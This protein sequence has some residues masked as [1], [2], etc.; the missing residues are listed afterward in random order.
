MPVK[1]KETRGRRFALTESATTLGDSDRCGQAFEWR[2]TRFDFNHLRGFFWHWT[3][4]QAGMNR[5]VLR[6]F[7]S[8]P[9]AISA[10]FQNGDLDVIG[11][12]N[13]LVFLTA[14][15]KHRTTPQISVYNFKEQFSAPKIH[16]SSNFFLSYRASILETFLAN[17]TRFS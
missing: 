10:N 17:Y 6:R 11:K 3:G 5:D 14:D 8:K 4:F 7:N 16:R 12:D 15:Y 2:S 1:V 9:D 13:L